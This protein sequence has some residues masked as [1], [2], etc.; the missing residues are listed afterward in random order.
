MPMRL[1]IYLMLPALGAAAALLV[2]VLGRDASPRAWSE[3]AEETCRGGDLDRD[4]DRMQDRLEA[5]EAL[6]RDWVAGRVTLT[7][8][9]SRHRALAGESPHPRVRAQAAA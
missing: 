2:A 8:A 5:R 3:L 1:W 7:E 9:V 4:V 6:A